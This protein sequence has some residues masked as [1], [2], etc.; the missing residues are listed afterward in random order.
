MK[1][2]SLAL[3]L[4]TNKITVEEAFKLSRI[5]EDYQAK[6]FGKVHFIYSYFN[7]KINANQ[8]EG[9]HDLRETLTMLALSSSKVFFDLTTRNKMMSFKSEK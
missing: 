1:S 8:V 2:T 7:K 4:V 6:L 5:E 9:E 3:S